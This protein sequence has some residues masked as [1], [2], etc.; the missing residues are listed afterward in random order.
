MLQA[1]AVTGRAVEEFARQTGSVRLGLRLEAAKHMGSGRTTG[2]S[3]PTKGALAD[4]PT[5]TA[6]FKASGH[7]PAA[8]ANSK[9]PRDAAQ[10]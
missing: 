8:C 6:V 3:R 7:C 1:D 4:G 2:R 10:G 5:N 9:G